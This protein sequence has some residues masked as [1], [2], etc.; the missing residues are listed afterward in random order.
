VFPSSTGYKLDVSPYFLFALYDTLGSN[1]RS[2]L[3]SHEQSL[4]I[5][6]LTMI[7]LWVANDHYHKTAIL[8]RQLMCHVLKIHMLGQEFYSNV[9]KVAVILTMWVPVGNTNRY[10]TCTKVTSHAIF[11]TKYACVRFLG[12][13]LRTSYLARTLLTI[14]S[15]HQLWLGKRCFHFKQTRGGP[16]STGGST[17]QSS[18]NPWFDGILSSS[19]EKIVKRTRS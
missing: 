13:K 10:Q 11:H 15:T 12:Y 3:F 16:F 9:I 18:P 8:V 17:N 1:E 6:P 14:S 19:Q 2:T 4:Y 7:Y 5:C